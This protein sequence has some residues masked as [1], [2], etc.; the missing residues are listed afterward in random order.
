MPDLVPVH[1]GLEAPVNRT[2]PLSRRKQFLDEA[3]G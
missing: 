1:G 3:L 2:V